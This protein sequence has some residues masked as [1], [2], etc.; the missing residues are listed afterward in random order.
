MGLDASKSASQNP[1]KD[2]L[3]LLISKSIHER[4]DRRVEIAEKIARVEEVMKKGRVEALG[5]EW[6]VDGDDMPRREAEY[7]RA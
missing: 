5:T 1:Q 4:I 6:R 2:L 3:E 7:E